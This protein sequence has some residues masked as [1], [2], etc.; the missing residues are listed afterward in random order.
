MCVTSLIFD[1]YGDKWGKPPYTFPDDYP[2][3]PN[4]PEFPEWPKI[5]PKPYIEPVQPTQPIVPPRIP[6]QEEIQEFH[7]L[8]RK[9]QEYDKKTGQPECDDA[10]K[11]AKL[12]ELAKEMGIKITFPKV[13]QKG[14]ATKKKKNKVK[15]K[16]EKQ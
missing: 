16:K 15:K 13:K 3:W 9:A 2:K 5:T 10:E 11:K 4:Y 14:I 1:H 7:E 8:L 6:T 12:K